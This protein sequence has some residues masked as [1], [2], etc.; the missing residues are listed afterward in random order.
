MP[1]ASAVE[2]PPFQPRRP[3]GP[4]LPDTTELSALG[5]FEEFF[6]AVALDRLILATTSYAEH[7]KNRK[8]GRYAIFKKKPL[9][10]GLLIAFLGVLILLGIHGVRNYRK[11]WSASRAQVMIRLNDLM[12]CQTF[13]VIGSFIHAITIEEECGMVSDPLRK[14]RPLQDLIKTKCQLLYQPCQFLSIDER[15]VK[16]KARCHFIQYMKNKPCKWGFKF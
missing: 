7:N 10:R 5:L 13:E 8:K 6:D 15:M 16:S 14:I 4:H 1:D 9:T 2:P 3:P 11:A 12:T